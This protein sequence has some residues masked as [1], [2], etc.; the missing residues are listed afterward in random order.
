[1][2]L[3]NRL[4]WKIRLWFF[5]KK[6]QSYKMHGTIKHPRL[7]S[8]LIDFI[9][10]LVTA[11]IAL[12]VAAILYVIFAFAT[13]M[14]VYVLARVFSLE[15]SQTSNFIALIAALIPLLTLIITHNRD[16]DE[17]DET[18]VSA[19]IIIEYLIELTRGNIK[20]KIYKEVGEHNG[21]SGNEHRRKK[22]SY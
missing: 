16:S 13:I 10:P 8:F 12:A 22:C 2:N 21:I 20:C 17:Y 3:C 19:K 9:S 15:S 4:L 18:K 5:D 14:V 1:M 7:W 11:I 6:N